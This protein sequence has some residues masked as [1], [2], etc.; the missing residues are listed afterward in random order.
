MVNTKETNYIGMTQSTTLFTFSHR[1]WDIIGK[2]I[3]II[4]L[5]WMAASHDQ[6]TNTAGLT[7][8]M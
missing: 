7:G 4:N 2:G 8:A 1:E 6:A 3:D 5:P